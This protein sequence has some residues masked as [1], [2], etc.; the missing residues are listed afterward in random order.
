MFLR[1]LGVLCIFC[2]LQCSQETSI[3]REETD[4]LDPGLRRLFADMPP[5]DASYDV[6]LRPNGVKE[7]GVI[8]HSSSPQDLRDAGITVGS[9]FG[10]I[11]TARVSVDELRRAVSLPTVRAVEQANR[12]EIPR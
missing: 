3:S 5:A 11:V 2:A 7:Y 1:L 8:I 6:S 12:S 10:D 9:V 4:K